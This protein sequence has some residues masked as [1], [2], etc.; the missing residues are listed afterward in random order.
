MMIKFKSEYTVYT[1]FIIGYIPKQGVKKRECSVY[2]EKATVTHRYKSPLK[3]MSPKSCT[4]CHAP[5]Q[6][7]KLGTQIF[8][9]G[10]P[11]AMRE[12]NDRMSAV[13]N[14]L[15]KE[16]STTVKGKQDLG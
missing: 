13:I 15:K 16:R 11:K 10:I 2:A 1:V 4:W 14:L 6:T 12:K 8:Y 5:Y 3:T 7:Q 9:V